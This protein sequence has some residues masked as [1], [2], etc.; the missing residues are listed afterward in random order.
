MPKTY[1]FLCSKH[2]ITDFFDWE[3]ESPVQISCPQCGEIAD[4]VWL[5]SPGMSPDPYWAGHHT[6]SNKLGYIT[7][8]TQLKERMEAAGQGFVER[9]VFDDAKRAKKQI[10]KE[11]AAARRKVI[12]DSLLEHKEI[13]QDEFHQRRLHPERY[14]PTSPAP[15]PETQV[16][17]KDINIPDTK[18]GYNDFVKSGS[19]IKEIM[20]NVGQR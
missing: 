5:S 14:R 18:E 17:F 15:S 20:K 19:D 4:K 11:N 3:N 13:L 8:R 1:D 9:G 12:A 10:E 7:S 2:H 16:E 6:G